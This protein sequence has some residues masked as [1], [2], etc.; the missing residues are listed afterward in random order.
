MRLRFVQFSIYK[1]HLNVFGYHK[2]SG[3]KLYLNNIRKTLVGKYLLS[4]KT[5]HPSQILHW[6][7]TD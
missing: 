2:L 6:S 5:C 3:Y 7:E 4:S 1:I